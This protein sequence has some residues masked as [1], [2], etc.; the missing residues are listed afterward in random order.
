MSSISDETI[1]YTMLKNDG[2]YPGDPQV[3]AIYEYYTLYDNRTFKIIYN[4]I[5]Q[6]NEFFA[7]PYC[8]NILLLWNNVDGLTKKGNEFISDYEKRYGLQTT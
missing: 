1:A 5:Y 7:S 3:Q 8:K 6:L 2:I 4:G